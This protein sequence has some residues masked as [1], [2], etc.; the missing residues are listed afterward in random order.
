MNASEDSKP[1]FLQSKE[2]PLEYTISMKFNLK[3]VGSEINKFADMDVN[4]CKDNNKNEDLFNKSIN[5]VELEKKLLNNVNHLNFDSF[6]DNKST[7]KNFKSSKS[8]MSLNVNV[9][10]IIHGHGYGN[11][12][13]INNHNSINTLN[14]INTN[15]TSNT[16]NNSVIL[17][18]NLNVSH[19]TNDFVDKY[20]S[21]ENN[22]SIE[23]TPD[24]KQKNLNKNI[25]NV[26]SN[27]NIKYLDNNYNISQHD[28]DNIKSINSKNLNS[29]KN[30]N[31]TNE[32]DK[33]DFLNKSLNVD[34]NL[35]IEIEEGLKKLYNQDFTA[36]LL[37]ENVNSLLNYSSKN[38]LSNENVI[39]N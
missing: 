30:D 6:L 14:T 25:I 19:L 32:N 35:M 33:L 22:D 38:E 4:T 20:I 23:N 15:I 16:N 21:N 27:E 39:K 12:H 28:N 11:E 3:N 8:E 5:F 9:D 1:V 17:N 10:N 37:N 7:S 36:N 2:D 24:E 26:I 13:D 34:Q 18:Q 29:N 31:N